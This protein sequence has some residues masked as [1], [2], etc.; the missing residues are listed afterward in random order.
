MG[1]GRGLRDSR[2][3]GWTCWSRLEAAVMVAPVV[4]L[5]AAALLVGL[6]LFLTRRRG[7]E[8]AGR[9]YRRARACVPAS[10]GLLSA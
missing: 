5:V 6:I 4:Y 10:S 3:S 8:A 1:V 2:A 7:R 9:R